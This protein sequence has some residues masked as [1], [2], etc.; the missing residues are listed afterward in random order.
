[1]DEFEGIT[2]QMLKDT[3]AWCFKN[4][5][6][7]EAKDKEQNGEGLIHFAS[8]NGCVPLVKK[9]LSEGADVDLT[10]DL[11]NTPLHIASAQ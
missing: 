11:K 3:L 9:L 2:M 8:E 10:D 1:M 5:N 6:I 7:L 4:T